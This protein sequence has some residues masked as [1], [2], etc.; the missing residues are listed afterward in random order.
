VAGSVIFSIHNIVFIVAD[1]RRT[2][3]RLQPL[4][5]RLIA[6]VK[7]GLTERL[8]QD[9]HQPVTSRPDISGPPIRHQAALKTP[10]RTIQHVD[11]RRSSADEEIPGR[12]H[13]GPTVTVNS[14]GF[15]HDTPV[16]LRTHAD[17][18]PASYRS[19]STYNISVNI[20]TLVFIHTVAGGS[21][22]GMG[23]LGP[24][25]L[26]RWAPSEFHGSR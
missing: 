19:T 1:F 20:T 5:S 13:G 4:R 24:S 23:T 10:G 11:C 26:G 21:R 14:S 18:T 6:A 25:S 9:E 22:G 2:S 3:D 8:I 12:R 15:D 17:T 7:S 16:T